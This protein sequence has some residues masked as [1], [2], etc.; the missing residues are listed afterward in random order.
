[1]IF[2]LLLAANVP[3]SSSMHN[4]HSSWNHTWMIVNKDSTI[5]NSISSAQNPK[6]TWF[7]DLYVDFCDP[8]RPGTIPHVW[9]KNPQMA[10]INSILGILC[11]F[12]SHSE[13]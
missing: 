1:M 9:L 8:L 12:H 5:A 11:P 7:S 2:F 6:E 13:K 4:P 10:G 3:S